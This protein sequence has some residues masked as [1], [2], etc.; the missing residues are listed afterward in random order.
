MVSR[1]A[2]SARARPA[3]PAAR[4]ELEAD[5]LSGSGARPGSARGPGVAGVVGAGAGESSDGDQ[6]MAFAA[7]S[8]EVVEISVPAVL[9]VGDVVDFSDGV[10][11]SAVGAA[12]L[13][14]PT[15]DVALFLG[16]EALAA[17]NV[18][19][20]A[21][22]GESCDQDRSDFCAVGEVGQ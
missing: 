2:R 13:L 1:S 5:R 10:V 11:A 18:K 8:D 12:A 17:A 6:R 21:V 15:D 14:A 20:S 4:T 7:Q 3:I 22:F 9:P 19:D 16:G